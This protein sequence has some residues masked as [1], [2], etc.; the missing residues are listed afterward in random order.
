MTQDTDFPGEDDLLD[1][2]AGRA[3]PEVSARI[4]AAAQHDPQ[5]AADIA[6]MRGARAALAGEATEAPPGA[7]GWAR[8][9]R[10]LDR[11]PVSARW[12][13]WQVAAASAV[14]TVL[15]WQ[16]VVVPGFV[17]GSDGGYVTATGTAKGVSATVAFAPESTEAQIR[18]LLLASGATITGGPSALG[19]W[20]LGFADAAAR[21]AALAQMRSAVGVVES[22]Q[23]N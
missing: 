15:L 12:P 16:F 8:L 5:L 2:I 22:V 17:A 23:G 14:A 11:A 7:L 18:A 3:A 19:F 1:H 20:T 21:D 13:A 4:E 9:E 6:L 10:A